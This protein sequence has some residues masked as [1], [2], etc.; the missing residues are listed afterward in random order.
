MQRYRIWALVFVIVTASA[1]AQDPESTTVQRIARDWLALTDAGNA[2]G[3]WD[4]AAQ[5]FKNAVTRE[6][7]VESLKQ[8]RDPLGKVDQ[9][10]VLST[11]F[12]TSFPGAPEGSYAIVLFRTSFE[13]K[14]DAAE[15]VTLQ[16]EPDGTW[17]IVG[18]FI[19]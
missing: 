8:A 19:R 13:K 18:Y 4:A 15:S 17:R 1:I 5:L 9:R 6:R 11:N 2:A 12:A 14:A 16:R 7:W 10:S 3:S